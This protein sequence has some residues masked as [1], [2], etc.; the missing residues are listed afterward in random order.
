V[1]A[2]GVHRQDDSGC[3]PGLPA[4]PVPLLPSWCVSSA[5]FAACELLPTANPPAHPP[6]ICRGMRQLVLGDSEQ[7]PARDV[8]RTSRK[9]GDDLPPGAARMRVGISSEACPRHGEG[10]ARGEAE[11]R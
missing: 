4:S 11:A 3:R 10:A 8:L 1:R 2:A 6:L 9:G 7:P 5:A